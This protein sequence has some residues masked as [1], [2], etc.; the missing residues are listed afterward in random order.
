MAKGRKD[1]NWKRKVRDW[2]SSK[3][4]I[5]VWCREQKIPYTTFLGWKAQLKKNESKTIEKP[6]NQFIELKETILS[7]SGILLEY[8]G[9]KIQLKLAF[10]KST[11]KEC[12]ESLRGFQC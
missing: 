3:K 6:T 7:D 1:P 11:L 9:V 4:S 2:E 8:H 10:D 5:P 12:L